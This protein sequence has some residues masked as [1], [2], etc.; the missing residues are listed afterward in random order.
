M[1]Q[2]T[3]SGYQ[4]GIV[5]ECVKSGL[6]EMMNNALGSCKLVEVA[7]QSIQNITCKG[8]STSSKYEIQAF[9]I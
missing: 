3:W 4:E 8:I 2:Q 6:L 7:K 1:H 5:N 9:N